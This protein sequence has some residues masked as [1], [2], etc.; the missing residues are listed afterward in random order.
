MAITAS[1]R[2]PTDSAEEP[3]KKSRLARQKNTEP[4]GFP[5]PENSPV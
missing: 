2:Q 1:K 5:G 3:K 4:V